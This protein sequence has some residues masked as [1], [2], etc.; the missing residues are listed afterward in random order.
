MISPDSVASEFCE[1]EVEHALELNKRIA[2]LALR[3]VPDAHIPE[4][5]R[6]RNWIPAGGEHD[7]DATI[8]RLVSALDTD[9]AWAKEHTRWLVKALEWDAEQRNSSFLLRGAELAAAERSL[10]TATATAKDP[11]PNTLQTEYLAAS[12]IAA[13][14]RQRTL[15]GASLAVSAV[16]IG[17][18]IFSLISRSDAITARNTA[19]AQATRATSQALAAESQTQ[20]AVDP[21]RSVVPLATAAVRQ[22]ATPQAMRVLLEGI[23]ARGVTIR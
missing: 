22:A 20:L 5:I 17:L 9:L 10:A 19:K 12:H 7:L 16:A 4:G 23:A 11:Q 1:Q 8:E 6:V 2:P 13:S 18:L 3:P 14:R 15:V 21:E